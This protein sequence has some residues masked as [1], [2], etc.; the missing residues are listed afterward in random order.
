MKNGLPSLGCHSI[1]DQRSSAYFSCASTVNVIGLLFLA[2]VFVYGFAFNGDLNSWDVAKVTTMD[3]ST[4]IRI[5][6]NDM[7]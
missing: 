1:F 3:S 5:V 6:E 4:S 7:T 2:T